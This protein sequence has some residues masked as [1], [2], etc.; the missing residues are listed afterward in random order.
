M[1]MVAV[2]HTTKLKLKFLK[3]DSLIESISFTLT[4]VENWLISILVLNDT[5][6]WESL[7]FLWFPEY[8]LVLQTYITF[9]SFNEILRLLLLVQYSY[10]YGGR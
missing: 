6:I 10:V 2:V 3:L 8:Y 1:C 7:F 5:S 9:I 4:D